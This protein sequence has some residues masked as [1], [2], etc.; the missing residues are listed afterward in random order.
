[1][2][3][4]KV[5]I[6]LIGIILLFII[7]FFI[8]KEILIR[9]KKT[10]EGNKAQIVSDNNVKANNST[11]STNSDE[12]SNLGNNVVSNTVA[13]NTS[14][15][16]GELQDNN[17]S[18]NKDQI[19]S[20]TS[21]D[22]EKNSNNT[23]KVSVI[24]SI[25]KQGFTDNSVVI[26]NHSG[27]VVPENVLADT[28]RQWILN[29]QYSYSGFADCNNTVWAKPWLD[30]ISNATLAGAFVEANGQDSP[31]YNVMASELNNAT[32]QLTKNQINKPWPLT[33]KQASEYI[34]NEFKN[35]FG[36]ETITKIVQ[37]SYG[38]NVYSNPYN[39]KNKYPI[40]VIEGATGYQSN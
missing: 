6:I 25:P 14:N 19:K 34:D 8:G 12:K 27:Q 13:K 5:I 4:L 15:S 31:Y 35:R 7:G 30:T 33:Y 29:W 38:Y 24:T 37:N 18:S 1:M 20:S 21:T 36:N 10:P 26:T 22:V 9:N 3:R 39:K 23:N 2:K 17:G 28:M 40:I 16:S 32:M 11:V